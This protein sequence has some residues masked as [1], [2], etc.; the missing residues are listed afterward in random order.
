MD[1]YVDLET[2]HTY[3]DLGTVSL[4]RSAQQFITPP[5]AILS[6]FVCGNENSS[7][8]ELFR[9]ESLETLQVRSPLILFGSSGVGKTML[10]HEL[11][12]RWTRL[13]SDRTST[14]TDGTEFSRVLTRSI[15]ADDM[16][17][18]RQ[19][20]RECDALLID[21]LHELATKPA[22][23]EEL[24][25]ILNDFDTAEK[26]F[27]GTMPELPRLCPLNP[28]L[29]SRLAA[30]LS[31]CISPPSDTAR[32]AIVNQLANHFSENIS[33][34]DLQRFCKKLDGTPT[35]AQLKGMLLRWGHQKRIDPQSKPSTGKQI[36][37]IVSS[38]APPKANCIDVLKQVAKEMQVKLDLLTG[39]SRKSGVVRARGLAMLLM[40]QLTEES[41]ESIGNHFSGRDHTTVMH[42]C[43]KTEKELPDDAELIRVYDKIRQKYTIPS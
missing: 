33:K 16:A 32:V 39:P 13:H 22:A 19:V 23:Q 43:K 14:L 20:Y 35:V 18:F 3:I 31:V 10:A 36:E 15:K 37:R 42:A 8:S 7:V 1:R 24:V 26:L 29:Q 25:A 40:R 28:A 17:R 27:I 30:G 12:Q 6:S 4:R 34:E 2:Q 9:P 38:L 5:S 41:F 11:L 21:N